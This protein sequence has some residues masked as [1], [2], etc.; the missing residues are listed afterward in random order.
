MSLIVSVFL[1][2]AGLAPGFAPKLAVATG[3]GE[4]QV[5]HAE[6]DF[7]GAVRSYRLYVPSTYG[8]EGPVPLFIALHGN[9]TDGDFFADKTG[10]DATAEREG[11]LVVYPDAIEGIWNGGYSQKTKD[12]DDVSFLAALVAELAARYPIDAQR[13]LATGMSG[14]GM[15]SYRLA[16]EAPELVAAIAPVGSTMVVECA[17]ALPVSVLHIHGVDDTAIPIEGREDRNMP[18]VAEVVEAWS[19][20]DG[21]GA[22]P[23]VTTEGA[24]TTT[25]WSACDSGTAVDFYAIDGLGHQYPRTD[26][27]APLDARDVTWTFLTE[28]PRSLPSGLFNLTLDNAGTGT[29]TVTSSPIGIDCG[30][31]CS[32]SYAVNTV[33]TLTAMPGTDMTFAGWSGGGCAGTALTCTVAMTAAVT[34]T[35][36]FNAASSGPFDLTVDKAG[37]GKGKVT[38]S[39]A[40]ITCGTDCSESYTAY[41]VVTLTAKPRLNT[42]FGGW[43][44]ACSGTAQTCTVAMTVA[45]TV[46]ASFNKA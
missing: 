15:M 18:P 22:G 9:G 35:A 25:S 29:G 23:Q 11:F 39:P 40:G 43:S 37:T 44:A 13:V 38:S 28:H 32:E 26:V 3:T 42:T 34:V 12:V 19:V 46:T 6:M 21:C 5:I 2:V 10:L 1:L 24:V 41:T 16:C 33:V 4:P 8:A 30:V 27:G 31:D 45:A 36:T 7:D 20:F 17:P 14:G